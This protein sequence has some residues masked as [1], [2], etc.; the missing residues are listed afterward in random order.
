[1]T[2]WEERINRVLGMLNDAHAARR[3]SVEEYRA[4][5]RALLRDAM[6]LGSGTSTLRRGTTT[7]LASPPEQHVV[8]AVTVTATRASATPGW[9]KLPLWFACMLLGALA[10]YAHYAWT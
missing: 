6:A 5:R 10:V 2:E 8:G 7:T 3:M 9:W 1:M 4:R